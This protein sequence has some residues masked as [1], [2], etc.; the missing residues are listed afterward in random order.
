MKI[1][2]LLHF[3]IHPMRDSK[4]IVSLMMLPIFMIFFV[5]DATAQLNW[6]EGIIPVPSQDDFKSAL[7]DQHPRI[8]V[9]DARLEEIRSIAAKDPEVAKWIEQAREKADKMLGEKPNIFTKKT[10]KDQLMVSRSVMD[11]VYHLAF[12]YRYDK[13]QKYLDRA[14]RELEAAAKF[15]NWG[16]TRT[17]LTT[18]EMIHAFGIG[19]DWLYHG[20]TDAQRT[21]LREAMWEKGLYYSYAGYKGDILKGVDRTWPYKTHNWNF[22]CNGGSAIGAMAIMDEK[23]HK[24]ECTFIVQQAFKFTQILLPLYDPDGAWQEG[25]MYWDYAM[26]YITAMLQ[27]MDSAFGTNFGYTDKLKGRGFSKTGDFPIYLTSNFGAYYSFS[28]SKGHLTFK[29]PSL[30]YLA[31]KFEKPLYQHYQRSVK[32]HT[33][34]DVIYYKPVDSEVNIL[35]LPLDRHFGKADIATMRSS[36]TDSAATFVGIKFGA[37][38][39]NAHSHYD[40]GSFILYDK[41]VKWFVDL[42]VDNSSYGHSRGGHERTEFYSKRTEGHNAVLINPSSDIMDAGQ[43]IDGKSVITKFLS[44]PSEVFLV[45]NLAKAYPDHVTEYKRGLRFFDHRRKILIRDEIKARKNSEMYWFGHTPAQIKILKGGKK[46]RLTYEG[47]VLYAHLQSPA[48]A[49]FSSMPA[50]PLPSSP[51]PK[52]K[53]YKGISK[54]AVHLKNMKECEIEIVLTPGYEFEEEPTV[55]ISSMPVAKWKLAETKR[56][57][58]SEISLDGKPLPGFKENVFTYTFAFPAETKD[59]RFPAIAAKGDGTVEITKAS[60]VPG[61]AIITL[62]AGSLKSEYRIYFVNKKN[63]TPSTTNT[64]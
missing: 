44:S 42:G 10:S 8:R 50:A 49:T 46:A 24:K 3:K 7:K 5:Q 14:Y 57:L 40:L 26:R 21:T 52:Q 4:T 56:P 20:L 16:P 33:L 30:F 19:Y 32:E 37:N 13:D 51:N 59:F 38:G 58:L 35:D 61:V 28:D 2:Y 12:F 27:S 64:K 41:G 9:N 15:P 23:P 39:F 1:F 45:A 62:T 48:E 47:K 22:V 55:S 43:P 31:Q 25:V 36:W 63:S 60:G 11:R 29:S 18:A 17:W 34:F 54:L 53:N 6:D